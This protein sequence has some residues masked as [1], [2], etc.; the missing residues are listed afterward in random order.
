MQRYPSLRGEVYLLPD[1][2]CVLSLSGELDAVAAPVLAQVFA[3]DIE[4]AQDVVID[5]SGASL[6]SAAAI[7][8]LCE[9]TGAVSD[10]NRRAVVVATGLSADM[11]VLASP[12]T[13]TVVAAVRDALHL[14][15]LDRDIALPVPRRVDVRR[16]HVRANIAKTLD[17]VCERY[18]VDTPDT[19]FA[20]LTA[21]SQRHNVPI[22]LLAGALLDVR[23]PS[24]G[25]WFPGRRRQAAPRLPFKPGS[26][27]GSTMARALDLM[28]ASTCSRFGSAQT[29]D[30]F[31]AGLSL[32]HQ[33]GF[34]P[35]FVETF[36]QVT[37]G[38]A[39]SLAYHT[40]EQTVVADIATD[41]RL[42]GTD[43]TNLLNA[44]VRAVQSTPLLAPSGH[45]LG[46]ISTHYSDRA[47]L[48]PAAE[49]SH[50]Q[51]VA[52]QVGGWLDW[53]RRTVVFDALEDLHAQAATVSARQS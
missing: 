21:A 46:V 38:T 42:R 36:A 31:H 25:Q 16:M 53:Y 28:M 6:V 32:D 41:D 7:G 4:P 37:D 19:A 5:V 26:T 34:E 20:L 24:G 18:R 17:V 35:D 1:T 33:R 23:E 12:S 11:L 51:T 30:P 14:I 45:C 2:V 47:D 39:C 9:F 22:R 52:E 49:L 8:V 44:R 50:V 29:V 40:R 13:L 48:P 43:Q 27:P 10:R 3:H 15:G